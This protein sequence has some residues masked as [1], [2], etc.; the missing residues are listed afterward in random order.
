MAAGPGP[1]RRRSERAA[2]PAAASP[3]GPGTALQRSSACKQ[4]VTGGS[5]PSLREKEAAPESDAARGTGSRLKVL[6]ENS[7]A[8]CCL[9]SARAGSLAAPDLCA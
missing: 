4:C 1:P 2:T 3:P 7:A 6:W 9:T 8:A 5:S